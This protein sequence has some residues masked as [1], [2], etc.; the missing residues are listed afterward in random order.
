[1]SFT[2]IQQQICQLD[3]VIA[4]I[5]AACKEQNQGVTQITQAVSQMDQTTQANAATAE[6]TAAGAE[7]L[8]QQAVALKHTVARLERLSGQNRADADRTAKA[9]AKLAIP[10]LPETRLAEPAPAVSSPPKSGRS[11]A[12]LIRV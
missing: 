11:A 1:M 4:G 5:A 12:K 8:N 9:E 7:E 2:T 6:E 10:S 3:E